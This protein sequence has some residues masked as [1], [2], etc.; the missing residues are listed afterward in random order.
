MVCGVAEP[1]PAQSRGNVSERARVG[2][3]GRAR[4]GNVTRQAG[5]F[6]KLSEACPNGPKFAVLRLLCGGTFLPTNTTDLHLRC[7]F[8]PD[9]CLQHM[10]S[11]TVRYS[12][13][14]SAK[15]LGH[16]CKSLSISQFSKIEFDNFKRAGNDA[17][18]LTWLG[19]W[20]KPPS[21][22]DF[23]RGL[24][25]CSAKLQS[26]ADRCFHERKIL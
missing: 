19:T 6:G 15:V 10:C 17:A 23:Y 8:H 26:A 25:C 3:Q 2:R 9:F 18:Y 20:Q 5:C 24:R 21:L 16:Q 22:A 13:T 1:A 14:Y 11:Y 7:R 12:V 4:Q